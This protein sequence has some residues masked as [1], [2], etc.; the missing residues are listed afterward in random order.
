[1]RRLLVLI[2]IICLTGCVGTH[3]EEL[4]ASIPVSRGVPLPNTTVETGA[5]FMVG[6]YELVFQEGQ[7]GEEVEVENRIYRAAEGHVLYVVPYRI[8]RI[9][10]GEAGLLPEAMDKERG[11]LG[12]EFGCA[13]GEDRY[14]VL[15]GFKVFPEA[16]FPLGW[17]KEDFVLC[18]LPAG[19][20]PWL[21]V[22]E[23]TKSG[24]V[25][26][27]PGGGSLPVPVPG[28]VSKP[29]PKE[30]SSEVGKLGL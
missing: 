26:P 29:I 13:G 1:M 8:T 2:A 14:T 18:H 28:G 22:S 20:E 30:G 15:R 3:L 27:A 25:L 6:D 24:V 17:Q 10:K 4:E 23:I 21:V 12:L 7:K 16:A 19:K 9:T 5:Q 11:Y